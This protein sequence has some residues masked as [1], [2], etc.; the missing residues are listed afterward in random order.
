MNYK[1]SLKESQKNL[2]NLDL[3]GPNIICI[4]WNGV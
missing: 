2:A 3:M 1:I 4:K